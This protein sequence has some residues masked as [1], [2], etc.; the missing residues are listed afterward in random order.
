MSEA[1]QSALA[2]EL[3]LEGDG[4]YLRLPRAT[5]WPEWARLRAASRDFLQ[6]WE[7]TWANDGLTREFYETR[8]DELEEA[9]RRGECVMFFIFRSEDNRLVGGI[10]L[11]N[12]RR[13]VAQCGTIGYWMG[14]PYANRGYMT[15]GLRRLIEYSFDTLELHRLEA[16]TVPGNVPS[17][18]LLRRAGFVTEG[19]ARGYLHIDGRWRDHIMYGLLRSDRRKCWHSGG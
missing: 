15:A 6:P 13:G 4:V 10:T 9:R 16:G 17:T 2:E 7:P 5:D 3:R 19:I 12:I 11:S 18:R 1:E 8:I 14:A